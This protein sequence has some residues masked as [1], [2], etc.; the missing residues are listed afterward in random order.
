MVLVE[1]AA[2]LAAPEVV[3]LQDHVRN[4]GGLGREHRVARPR[5][6]LGEA[7]GLGVAV[8]QPEVEHA[9]LL[10]RIE[11]VRAQIS[12]PASTRR[13]ILIRLERWVSSDISLDVLDDVDPLEKQLLPSVAGNPQ[14]DVQRLGRPLAQ[15]LGE[16]EVLVR[17]R[18]LEAREQVHVEGLRRPLRIEARRAKGRGRVRHPERVLV[19]V[20]ARD[21]F[22]VSEVDGATD[23]ESIGILQVHCPVRSQPQGLALHV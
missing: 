5:E 23:C 16:A 1:D 19:G 15:V 12:E 4:A 9:R 7:V 14:P 10:S 17:Q 18:E 11:V 13:S 20:C 6:A 3:E 22:R 21:A 8:D 2:G